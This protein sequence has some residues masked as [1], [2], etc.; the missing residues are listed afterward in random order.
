MT[1]DS[2]PV[3]FAA[4][5]VRETA[6]TATVCMDAVRGKYFAIT[7]NRASIILHG[8][9]ETSDVT[10]TDGERVWAMTEYGIV[11]QAIYRESPQPHWLDSA[12][13]VALETFTQWRALAIFG[14]STGVASVVL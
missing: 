1:C 2:V 13:Y 5:I 14:D 6:E 4:D 3:H 11:R 12:G 8:W 9:T 7:C 10:P